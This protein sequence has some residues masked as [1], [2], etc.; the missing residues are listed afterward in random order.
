MQTRCLR[1]LDRSYLVLE[2]LPIREGEYVYRMPVSNSLPEL[3]PMEVVSRDGESFLRYDITACSSL[4]DTCRSSQLSG[5][6]IRSVL[7]GVRDAA[8]R[9][10]GFLLD[11]RDLLLDPDYI[12][13][14]TSDQQM[15]F[16]FVPHLSESRE[17]SIRDLAEFLLRHLDHG[18]NTG[19]ELA[20]LF[21]QQVSEESFSIQDV[22]RQILNP[23]DAG[24][25]SGASGSSPVRQA[26]GA[27]GVSGSSPVGPAGFTPG[28]PGGSPAGPIGSAPG[29]VSGGATLNSRSGF[30][31]PNSVR[32]APGGT[33]GGKAGAASPMHSVSPVRSASHAA[34]AHKGR[35]GSGQSSGRR[36]LLPGLL[37]VPA[38]CLIAFVLIWYFRM[39]LPQI[40][41][42]LLLAAAVIWIILRAVQ[43][44]SGDIR[45]VWADE[46]EDDADDD[47]FYESLRRELC[48]DTASAAYAPNA[49]GIAG[50]P[51]GRSTQA[52][53]AAYAGGGSVP[54]AG[55]GSFSQTGSVPARPAGGYAAAGSDEA[56]RVLVPS[57]ADSWTLVSQDPGHFPDI[58]IIRDQL[59]IGKSHAKADIALAE[60]T[61]S[62]VHAR[63]DRNRDGLFLTDLFSTNGTTVNGTR[64]E[65]NRP[66]ALNDGDLVAFA[67][68]TYTVRSGR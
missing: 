37:I 4:A 63:L 27:S 19:V 17:N 44:K 32:S 42:L 56:T 31:G 2:D 21:Y 66:R 6:D 49:A 11:S 8:V 41:A 36:T 67:N 46:L 64:L 28:V 61:V 22:L 5:A 34:G 50:A 65:S 12:Y 29:A 58:P 26:G 3:L 55:A 13:R 16:C 68:A 59:V 51:A 47:A 10:G 53:A 30:S 48:D 25:A 40:G 9:L 45:N 15:L 52:A 14:R 43:R 7:Y 39:D 24:S 20:Y 57:G 33:A 38:L 60:T 35:K 1:E 23:S 18:D 62:R 54:P